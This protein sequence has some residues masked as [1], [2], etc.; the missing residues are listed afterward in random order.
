MRTI[1]AGLLGAFLTIEGAQAAECRAGR[2]TFVQEGR[3]FRVT[4]TSLTQARFKGLG[5]ERTIFRGTLG[6]KPYIID[7]QGVQGSSTNFTSYA[8]RIAEKTA[9]KP[10]WGEVPR[11]WSDGAEVQIY[12]GPLRGDWKVR[13]GA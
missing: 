11:G 3:T 6:G 8:G 12:D 4:D 1:W 2:M 10:N 7:V 13:C 5:A 9:M